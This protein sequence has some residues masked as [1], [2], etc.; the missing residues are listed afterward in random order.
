MLGGTH[1]TAPPP[2]I[3]MFVKFSDFAKLYRRESLT[4]HAI[5]TNF[6]AFFLAVLK[7]FRVAISSHKLRKKKTRGRGHFSKHK[8]RKTF[9]T[10]KYC[11]IAT[12]LKHACQL[13][14]I[15][16]ESHGYDANLP[17]TRTG[18]QMSDKIYL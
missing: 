10:L 3:Q 14:R 12:E 15:I 17:V 16:W 8:M 4:K 2:T 1:L 7:D 5:F 18:H 13:S 11:S 6:K 9:S